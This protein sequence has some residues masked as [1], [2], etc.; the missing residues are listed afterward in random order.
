MAGSSERIRNPQKWHARPSPIVLSP[1]QQIL[2][3]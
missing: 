1:D 2:D 3:P